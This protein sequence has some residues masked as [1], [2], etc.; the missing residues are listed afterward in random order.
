MGKVLLINIMCK[1]SGCY[2][3]P[4]FP[5]LPRFPDHRFFAPSFSDAAGKGLRWKNEPWQE[6]RL[7]T[8]REE[9]RKVGSG[10]LGKVNISYSAISH[11]SQICICKAYYAKPVDFARLSYT[12]SLTKFFPFPCGVIHPVPTKFMFLLHQE[13]YILH[14]L[15]TQI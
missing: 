12:Y 2:C 7:D 1:I 9:K 6:G 4:E 10:L 11:T 8:T 15:I 3:T 14:N 5:L 13:T